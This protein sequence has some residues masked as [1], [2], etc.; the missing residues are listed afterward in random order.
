MSLSKQIKDLLHARLNARN[1]AN[2]ISVTLPCHKPVSDCIIMSMWQTDE[3]NGVKWSEVTQTSEK[4][5]QDSEPH[6]FL[7]PSV[8]LGEASWSWTKDQD[9][10]N[11]ER[12]ETSWTTLEPAQNRA[13]NKAGQP[14]APPVPAMPAWTP[15][16][17]RWGG[18]REHW[19]IFVAQKMHN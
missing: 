11:L 2:N 17:F 5:T 18:G 10:N 16:T 8:L 1:T 14:Q 13:R 12:T 9:S 4:Q 15:C 3:L 19:G 6:V 7:S